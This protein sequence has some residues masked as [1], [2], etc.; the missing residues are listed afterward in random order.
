M[1]GIPSVFGLSILIQQLL[2]IFSTSEIAQHSYY[3]V[4]FVALS[5]L[6]FGIYAVIAQIITLKKKTKIDGI[7]WMG[8]AFLNLGLNFFFI[9]KFGI[10]GA[11][12]TTLAAYAL[13]LILT[14]Y[15]FFKGFNLKL[16]GNLYLKAFLLQF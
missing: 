6:L 15:Y 10:L 4:P 11:A 16:T 8:A 1:V 5:T 14:W 7:I 13:A 12:I 3:I 2:T 9:P